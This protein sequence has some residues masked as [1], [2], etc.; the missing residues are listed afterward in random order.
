[1]IPR[2]A[3]THLIFLA[4]AA[5]ATGYITWSSV[6]ASMRVN[7]LV[8]VAPVAVAI[9]I[10]VAFILI[11]TLLQ[12]SEGPDEEDDASKSLSATVADLILLA[13][14]A[15]FCVALTTVGFDIATFLFVWIG[16]VLGGERRLWLPPLFSAAF[17]L[18]L[19]YGL[20]ALFPFP[21][22]MLVL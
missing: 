9:A 6:A 11:R 5:L 19:V 3:P 7:N 14:F 21:M 20:G 2:I 17:T 10:L 16:I 13:L 12:K 1:M 15:V 22:P 8:I 4:I 18:M